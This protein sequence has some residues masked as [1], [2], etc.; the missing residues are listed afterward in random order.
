VTN[1]LQNTIIEAE[2][3]TCALTGTARPK[4]SVP[5]KRQRKTRF[6]I[7]AGDVNITHSPTSDIQVRIRTMEEA[8][9]F[10][11]LMRRKLFSSR[12]HITFAGVCKERTQHVS[13][14]PTHTL[15]QCYFVNDRETIRTRRAKLN[16]RSLATNAQVGE[17]N[18]NVSHSKS[19]SPL[20]TFR[21]S[22]PSLLNKI[23]FAQ[24]MRQPIKSTTKRIYLKLAPETQLPA[25]TRNAL[26]IN[27][28]DPINHEV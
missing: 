1:T 12:P 7:C 16:S 13:I 6:A 8:H 2:D 4:S 18:R 11:Y 20:V 24:L 3:K 21:V 9:I 17:T 22:F 15:K 5:I 25:V 27:D 19:K 28:I 14:E 26:E 23:A 10:A